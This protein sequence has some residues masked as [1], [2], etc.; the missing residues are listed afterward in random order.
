MAPS[1]AAAS[2]KKVECFCFTQ[3]PL[4]PGESKELPVYFYV[5]PDLDPEITTLTLSYTVFDAERRRGSAASA[6]DDGAHQHAHH[7]ADADP[8]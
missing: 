7:S 8:S 1:R 6:S 5:D 3:Q 2:L 4:E